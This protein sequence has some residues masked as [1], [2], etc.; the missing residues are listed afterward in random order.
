MSVH[1]INFAVV[2]HCVI[3]IELSMLLL[4]LIDWSEREACCGG[5]RR[6]SS[7]ACTSLAYIKMNNKLVYSLRHAFIYLHYLETEGFVS[8]EVFCQLVDLMV[9]VPKG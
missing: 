8:A 9:N 2:S 7:K 5:I 3:S 4:L 1:C 6:Y